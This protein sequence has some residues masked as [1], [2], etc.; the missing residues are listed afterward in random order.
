MTVKFMDGDEVIADSSQVPGGIL[1]ACKQF[2]SFRRRSS[3][4]DNVDYILELLSREII[5]LSFSNCY[6]LMVT[7][8]VTSSRSIHHIVYAGQS[9]RKSVTGF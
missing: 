7:S 4:H 1:E 6:R 5:G 9:K 2:E 8:F 3:C